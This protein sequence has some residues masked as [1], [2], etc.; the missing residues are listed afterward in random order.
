M[1]ADKA[2]TAFATPEV[3]MASNVPPVLKPELDLDFL[4]WLSQFKPMPQPYVNAMKHDRWDT[5]DAL[6]QVTP[7]DMA[8]CDMKPGH[9]LY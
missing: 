7:E 6:Q 4:P 5:V 1:N 2:P 8:A 3:D 9:R